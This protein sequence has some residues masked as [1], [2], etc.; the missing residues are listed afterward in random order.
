MSTLRRSARGA[1]VGANV[2]RSGNA[3]TRAVERALMRLAGW[4][5]E[6]EI[7]DEPKLVLVGAPHT[8]NFDFA[9]TK[10]AAAAVGVRIS[11][12]GK[13][14]LFPGP[15]GWLGRRLGGIPVD[16][17]ASTGFVD[18]MAD[19]FR[20]R[21]R[22]YLALMPAGSRSTPDSWRSGFYYIARAADVPIVPIGFDWAHRTVRLGPVIRLRPDGRYD[23][24]VAAIRSHFDGLTGLRRRAAPHVAVQESRAR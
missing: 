2:P 4:R 15:V 21:D 24:D 3:A 8:T 10:I 11:W 7:P 20:R 1:S 6:G 19:E 12:V 9:V 5:I 22:F 16:R 18:A 14:S 23:D 17:A 13:K